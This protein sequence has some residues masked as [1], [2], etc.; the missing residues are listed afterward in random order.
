MGAVTRGRRRRGAAVLA[1]VS[2]AVVLA[3]G[4][5]SVSGATVTSTWKAKIGSAG[6]NGT[7]TI[8][9]YATGTG[10]LVLRLAN[11]RAATTLPVTLSKGTCSRVGSTLIRFPAIR[12]TSRGSAARTSSLTAAQVNLVK[13][14]TAGTGTIAI[15]VGSTAT[16]GTKCGEFVPQ[17]A[18]DLWVNIQL[19]ITAHELAATDTGTMDVPINASISGRI[20]TSGQAPVIVTGNAFVGP[21]GPDSAGCTWARTFT[22]DVLK[23]TVYPSDPASV[24]V[25]LEGPDW[26]YVVQCPGDSSPATRI[27][28]FGDEGLR[29]FLEYALWPDHTANGVRLPTAV[30]ASPT[31]G[32]GCIKRSASYTTSA[33]NADV[34]V[35]VFVYQ[36]D[37][38]GG[39][40][41]PVWP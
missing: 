13:N 28:A 39:C 8:N 37:Y 34:F 20:P 23:L 15:R 18:A 12:T 11:L 2:V 1:V 25:G 24:E 36:P 30:Y 33:F 29:Y 35:G 14:A 41:L 16:G 31:G 19:S 4:P 40:L 9:V 22:N 10:A 27:P 7:A 17:G 5:A 32:S 3:L 21:H 26:Y 38:P 6:A